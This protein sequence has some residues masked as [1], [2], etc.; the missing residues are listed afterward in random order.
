MKV[1]C[2]I[3]CVCLVASQASHLDERSIEV[4]SALSR[5]QHFVH[6]AMSV[7]ISGCQLV[8]TFVNAP[9]CVAMGIVPEAKAL[10]ACGV[11]TVGFQICHAVVEGVRTYCSQYGTSLPGGDAANKII[12]EAVQRKG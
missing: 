3:L 2:L 4:R 11:Y 5:V 8:S 9:V 12:C 1:F 7:A 10:E 6:N